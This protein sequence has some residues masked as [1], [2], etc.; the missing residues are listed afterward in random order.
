LSQLSG[1]FLSVFYIFHP[2][3]LVELAHLGVQTRARRYYRDATSLSFS[4]STAKFL[5]CCGFVLLARH[6]L[7]FNF[8]C[9]FPACGKVDKSEAIFICTLMQA[10]LGYRWL[11]YGFQ[12][13]FFG[14]H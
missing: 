8:I 7:A 14:L 10:V 6:I 5:S 4:L 9:H 13:G 2:N 11:M 1:L 12:T 3:L